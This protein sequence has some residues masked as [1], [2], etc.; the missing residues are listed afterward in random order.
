MSDTAIEVSMQPM[1]S[2]DVV[3]QSPPAIE[4]AQVT[5]VSVEVSIA[6]IGPR[7]EKGDPGAVV[8][9]EEVVG[10]PN[11]NYATMYQIFKL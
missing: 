4:V 5:P 10:D 2:I 11:A 7:G 8:G 1:N 6:T 9:V 3:S